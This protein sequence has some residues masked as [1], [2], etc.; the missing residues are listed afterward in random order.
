MGD[1]K[2]AVTELWGATEDEWW[3]LRGG[4]VLDAG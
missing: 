4:R 2:L 1:V 3:L